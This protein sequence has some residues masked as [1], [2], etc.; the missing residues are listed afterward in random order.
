MCVV[1]VVCVFVVH[2]CCMCIVFVTRCVVHLVCVYVC[3]CCIHCVYVQLNDTQVSQ[4]FAN[5]L[6]SRFATSHS[7]V[8]TTK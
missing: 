8:V 3:M 6:R 4:I 2:V 5:D 7:H 1:F